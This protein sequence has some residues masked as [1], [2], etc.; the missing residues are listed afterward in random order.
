[1]KE[2]AIVVLAAGKGKRMKSDLAKVLHRLCG[3]P[4]LFYVLKL[5]RELKPAKTVVVVGRQKDKVMEEFGEWNVEFVE[6]RELLGTGDAV[7]QA[8]SA[9]E[10]LDADVLVL[11][12]DTPLLRRGTIERM[13][14]VHQSGGADITLLSAIAEDPSGYGRIV[15][16]GGE[17]K[18]IVEEKDATD[19]EKKIRE[20][21]AGVYLFQKQKL[22]QHLRQV[23]PDNNQNEYYLT[24]VVRLIKENGGQVLVV[25]ADTSL[26]TVG[27]NDRE[28]L[29]RIEKVMYERQNEAKEEKER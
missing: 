15:R 21:N 22:F 20:I 3:K 29:A 18:K 28:T 10:G 8:A 25:T 9:L 27:I 1:M 16:G 4:M 12:G 24:D 7:M 13:L 14:Q 19:Q 23:R 6:Q 17:V 11:A 5:T 2:L 26:E